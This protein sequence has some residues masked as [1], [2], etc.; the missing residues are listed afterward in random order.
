MVV[1]NNPVVFA[2]VCDCK[3]AHDEHAV[4]RLCQFLCECGV[5]HFVCKSDQKASTIALVNEVL[6]RSTTPGDMYYGLIHTAVSENSAVG[7]AGIDL[8][9]RRKEEIRLLFLA[10]GSI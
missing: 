1:V 10:F 8:S 9:S 7:F 6:R 5:K 2:V 3:G 4:G